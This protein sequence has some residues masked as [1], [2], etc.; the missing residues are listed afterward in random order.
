MARTVHSGIA[1]GKQGYVWT[2]SDSQSQTYRAVSA[3]T[4]TAFGAT[5]ATVTR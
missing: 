3:E 5:F 2:H 4:T 1:H